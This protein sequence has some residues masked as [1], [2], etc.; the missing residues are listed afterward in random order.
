MGKV[1]QLTIEN[2]SNWMWNKPP[3][4]VL[5]NFEM[6]TSILGKKKKISA[7]QKERPSLQ[8]TLRSYKR[9]GRERAKKAPERRV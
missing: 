8:K 4:V 6:G 1:V 7:S 9:A 2:G 3:P 5:G